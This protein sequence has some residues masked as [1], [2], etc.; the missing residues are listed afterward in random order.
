M[1]RIA[2][3]VIGVTSTELLLVATC[4]LARVS[5]I[6]IVLVIVIARVAQ[7]T[8][9]DV[10][11]A[12]LLVVIRRFVHVGEAGH[13]AERQVE[14]TTAQCKSP[15]HPTDCIRRLVPPTVIP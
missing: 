3:V 9:I 8:V 1:D 6:V 11:P 14:G 10:Q 12:I 13:E 5:V 15:S 4:G 2:V 7:V